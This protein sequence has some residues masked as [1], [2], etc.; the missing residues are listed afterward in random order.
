MKC[1][2][3]KGPMENGFTTYTAD[4]GTCVVIIRNVPCHRCAQCGEVSFSLD[5]GERLEQIT[6][7]LKDSVTEVAIIKYTDRAA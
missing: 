6:E 4:L 7:A 5:V 3:C 2:F 1:F